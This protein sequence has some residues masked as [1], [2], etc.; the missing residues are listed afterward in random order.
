M[1]ER[2]HPFQVIAPRVE[3]RRAVDQRSGRISSRVLSGMAFRQ[4]R[5]TPRH[6]FYLG[7]SDATWPQDP[8]LARILPGLMVVRPTY[9]FVRGGGRI[10]EYQEERRGGTSIGSM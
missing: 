1:N 4:T 2:G 10:E 6:L 5:A 9:Q 8:R 7:K 3:S